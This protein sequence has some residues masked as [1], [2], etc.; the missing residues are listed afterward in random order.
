M[1]G[2]HCDYASDF[3]RAKAPGLCDLRRI[4]PDLDRGTALVD[5]DVGRFVWLMAEE[6]EAEAAL[7]VNGGHETSSELRVPS[8][9]PPRMDRL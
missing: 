2:Y 9:L 5:V 8:H 1:L 4:Q 3:V 7:A 6:V